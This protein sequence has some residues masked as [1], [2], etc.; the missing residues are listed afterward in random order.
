MGG[1]IPEEC[2]MQHHDSIGGAMCSS[3]CLCN[4]GVSANVLT[5]AQVLLGPALPRSLH[6][7]QKHTSKCATV[8]YWIVF[9]MSHLNGSLE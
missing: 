8:A 6:A 7:Q 2:M 5:A 1:D 4:A 9:I 3:V